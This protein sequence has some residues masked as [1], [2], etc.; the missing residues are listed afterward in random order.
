MPPSRRTP[1]PPRVL[2]FQRKAA[3]R[4]VINEDELLA[5]LS[6]YGEVRVVEF[7]ASTPFQEQLEAVAGTGVFVSV[8]TSNLANAVLLRPGCAVVELIQVRQLLMPAAACLA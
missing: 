4:R 3:N 8:H 7:N 2:T 6:R 1:R 5:V